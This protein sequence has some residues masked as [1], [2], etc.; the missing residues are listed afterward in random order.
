M[1]KKLTSMEEVKKTKKIEDI[2][3]IVLDFLKHYEV[4]KDDSQLFKP[5]KR[6]IKDLAFN[7]LHWGKKRGVSC[8]AKEFADNDRIFSKPMYD[9]RYIKADQLIK[10]KDPKKPG[11]ALE[12]DHYVT[13]NELSG[14]LFALKKPSL[15]D[16]INVMEQ[17]S[18]NVI[19]WQEHKARTKFDREN[20][21]RTPKEAYS[22]A[23]IELFKYP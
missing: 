14:K 22:F 15:Q 3:K 12:L 5:Y 17:A 10:L 16:V 7:P 6:L 19:T 20:K 18:V 13:T 21:D 9:L 11:A 23:K 8:A 4:V 2:A 1:P